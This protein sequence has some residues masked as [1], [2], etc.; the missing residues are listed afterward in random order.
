MIG[1]MAIRAL[2]IVGM[3]ISLPG[4]VH[5]PRP[6]FVIVW[7]REHL[8]SNVL[9]ALE[10]QLLDWRRVADGG[11]HILPLEL[12]NEGREPLNFRL[13]SLDSLHAHELRC[14]VVL[15]DRSE[16]GSLPTMTI[17]RDQQIMAPRWQFFAK[18]QCLRIGVP[19]VETPV[20][21]SPRRH[22]SHAALSVPRARSTSRPSGPS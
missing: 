16:T 6:I 10:L 4:L 14:L 8:Q 3:A 18:H 22:I 21:H 15:C 19:E 1:M 13:Q 5:T 17:S 9:H 2:T 11:F 12:G 20:P 7:P